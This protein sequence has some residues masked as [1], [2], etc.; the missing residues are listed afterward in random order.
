SKVIVL[1]PGLVPGSFDGVGLVGFIHGCSGYPVSAGDG[2]RV[3]RRRTGVPPGPLIGGAGKKDR[4]RAPRDRVA[5][6]AII[7]R[8]GGG[9][10]LRSRAV[11]RTTGTAASAPKSIP[12]IRRVQTV[13]KRHRHALCS[14][15]GNGLQPLP[16]SGKDSSQ[17]IH[18]KI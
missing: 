9:G 16:P 4:L 17:S 18:L 8:W 6:G 7:P 14:Q 11:Q 13:A 10:F 3:P 12:N 5:K 1:L 2:N 15:L